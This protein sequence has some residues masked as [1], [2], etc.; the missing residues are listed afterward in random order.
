MIIKTKG[1]DFNIGPF[2]FPQQRQTPYAWRVT[3]AI[4]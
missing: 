2:S 4:V 1:L 3:I